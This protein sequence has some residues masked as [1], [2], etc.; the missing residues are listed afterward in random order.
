[1]NNN[2]IKFKTAVIENDDTLNIDY[3]GE[4]I[5]DKVLIHS[6]NNNIN[7]LN[8]LPSGAL[9]VSLDGKNMFLAIKVVKIFGRN[10]RFIALF[11]PEVKDIF[12]NEGIKILN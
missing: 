5:V 6:E 3:Y 1:M 4:D 12:E 7:F 9:H 11:E 10:E 2:L 8:E